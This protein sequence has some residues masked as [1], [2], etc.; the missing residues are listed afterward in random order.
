MA[1]NGRKGTGGRKK[2][3]SPAPQPK[4]VAFDYVKSNYFR[5]VHCDGVVGGITPTGYLHM[6]AWNTRQPFPR[7]V[8]HELTPEGTMGR[9]VDRTAREAEIIREIEVDLVFAPD[10][11]RVIIRWL[12][13]RLAELDKIAAGEKDDENQ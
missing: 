9:E 6:A 3:A 4:K 11:A 7:Q 1:Q 10:M 12:E 5:V 8:V 2:A 13:A